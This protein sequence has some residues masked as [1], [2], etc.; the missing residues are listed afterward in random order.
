M[1]KAGSNFCK[2]PLKKKDKD[3]K[4][5]EVTASLA[6]ARYISVDAAAAA[7]LAKL[8]GFYHN[9]TEGFCFCPVCLWK[10]F[11]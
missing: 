7:G 8:D 6:D 4:K 3:G 5:Q 10:E 1:M 11:S 9:N 2:L